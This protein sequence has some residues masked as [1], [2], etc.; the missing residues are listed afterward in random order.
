[1]K[2]TVEDQLGYEIPEAEYQKAVHRAKSKHRQLINRYGTTGG[3]RL[4]ADYM[5]MLIVE[6]ARAHKLSQITFD[7]AK[8]MLDMEKEHSDKQKC[9]S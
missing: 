7:V 9:P 5:V 2:Q 3:A 1:M 8:N 6:M 4:S